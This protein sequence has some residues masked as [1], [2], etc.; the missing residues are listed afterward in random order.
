MKVLLLC[1]EHYH[2]GEVPIG[3]TAPLKEKGYE[4]DIIKDGKEFKAETL[5]DYPVV[6]MC[7]CDDSSVDDKTSW[8][9]AAVQQ[10]FI[11][12]VERGGGLMVIHNGTVPGEN[13]EAMDRLAGSK[14]VFHP[15]SNPVTVEPVKPHYIT[16]GVEQFTET[17]EHYH[18][19]ILAND[20]DIL[21]AS[22]APAQGS[23]DKYEEDKYHNAPAKV[24]PSVYVRSQGKGRVCVMTPGHTVTV[25]LNPQ[26]QRLLDNGLKWCARQD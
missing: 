12:Y 19:E 22:Y 4:F 21:A 11:D 16:Q 25:W 6:M 5:K 17:D 10:A 15:N 1:D 7:K 20:I 23:P 26:F 18:L 8:K 24:C 2:P 3:G 14:F 9:S 13:T